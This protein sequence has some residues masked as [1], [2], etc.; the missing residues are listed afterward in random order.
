[1]GGLSSAWKSVRN[2]FVSVL[3]WLLIAGFA[4][5]TLDV[6]WGVFSRYVVGQ[7]SRWTEEI[8]I[9]LLVWVSLIGAS[10]TYAD[11]GHLGVDYFVGKLHPEARRVGAIAT[12]ILVMAFAAFALL[13]GG[14]VLIAKTLESGQVSPA[15]GV[16]MGY[17][18]SA[19]PVSGV[20]FLLFSLE[21][22][23]RLLRN[24]PIPAGGSS[25]PGVEEKS[26]WKSRS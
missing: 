23:I 11:K 4:A 5:L 8:A 9:Y 20:F 12:E 19:A 21:N 25:A 13:Y 3:E 17:L 16:K 6:L 22:I 14:G 26:R 18:Y 1:M 15:L 10:L 2:A 7:Q 24:D